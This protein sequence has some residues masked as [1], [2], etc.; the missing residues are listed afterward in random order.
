MRTEMANLPGKRPHKHRRRSKSG[1]GFFFFYCYVHMST[2]VVVLVVGAALRRLVLF[3]GGVRT[4]Q[5]FTIWLQLGETIA[6]HTCLCRH[7]VDYAVY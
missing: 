2:S 5:T 4:D 1:A 7:T 3:S 6:R